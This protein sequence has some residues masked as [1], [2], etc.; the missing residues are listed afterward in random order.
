M[1]SLRRVRMMLMAWRSTGENFGLPLWMSVWGGRAVDV[2]V[3]GSVP[4]PCSP[5][6]VSWGVP[7]NTGLPLC[8]QC[9]HLVI[10]SNGLMA[11]RERCEFWC[12]APTR[13]AAS[14]A[15]I[16]PVPE[17]DELPSPGAGRGPYR[18]PSPVPRRSPG[19]QAAELLGC[20]VARRMIFFFFLRQEEQ[21][22][23]G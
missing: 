23:A 11:E 1:W 20:V 14:A 12:P 15:P 3:V 6:W 8:P 5:D 18:C 13:W 19:L 22:Q 16:L 7:E 9:L 21:L 17:L 4:V 2:P 10:Y